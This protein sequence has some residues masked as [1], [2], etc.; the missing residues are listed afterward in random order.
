MCSAVCRLWSKRVALLYLLVFGLL[1][2]EAAIWAFDINQADARQLQSLNGIGPKLAER[3]LKER[4]KGPFQDFDDLSAR[5]KG[6]GPARI[7]QWRAEGVVVSPPARPLLMTKPTP[8]SGS[9]QAPASGSAGA[10][11]TPPDAAPPAAS[12]TRSD[13]PRRAKARLAEPDDAGLIASWPRPKDGQG[14]RVEII[15]GGQRRRTP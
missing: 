12:V 3:V 7:R 6:V 11:S 1:H 5:V 4:A 8:L 2:P 10:R 13:G 15:Q 14:T 9:G